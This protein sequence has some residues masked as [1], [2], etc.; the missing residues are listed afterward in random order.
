MKKFRG[1][2]AQ[3]IPIIFCVLQ[4]TSSSASYI[5]EVYANIS[6]LHNNYFRD[7]I[8]PT[9]IN[10]IDC[11][12]FRTYPQFGYALGIYGSHPVYKTI[13]VTIGIQY[14]MYSY[15]NKQKEEVARSYQPYFANPTVKTYV[16]YDFFQIPL[17][18]K[19]SVKKFIVSCGI[20]NSVFAI[21]NVRG[22]TFNDKAN[23][24]SKNKLELSYHLMENFSIFFPV[25]NNIYL[26]AG[27][28]DSNYNSLFYKFGINYFFKKD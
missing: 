6:I 1:K 4:S 23:E 12:G 11:S 3:I 26:S 15:L 17:I 20:N 14:S 2:I 24:V 19:V 18:L 7:P 13:S 22:Y 8:L 9:S 5:D 21:H 10:C 27:I 16:R 25:A 28:E